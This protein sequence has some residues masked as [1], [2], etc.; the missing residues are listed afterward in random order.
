MRNWQ[1]YLLGL[2]ASLA[3]LLLVAFVILRSVTDD[4]QLKARVQAEIAQAT[5]AE[6]RLGQLHLS[7]SPLPQL[8]ASAVE[9]RNPEWQP[10]PPMKGQMREQM[11]QQ[12]SRQ[13]RMQVLVRAETMQA[14]IALMPL[15]S[16]RFELKDIALKGAQINLATDANGKH[17]WD[18]LYGHPASTQQG[19]GASFQKFKNT[20]LRALLIE[21]STVRVLDP[22]HGLRTWQIKAL[23]FSADQDLSDASLSADLIHQQHQLTIDGTI[24][25]L[26]RLGDEGASSKSAFKLKIGQARATVKGTL[27]LDRALTNFN[28]HV[29]IDAPSLKDPYAF[30]EIP[31]QST[32]ALK[33]AL[34]LV[35]DQQS[36]NVKDLQLQLG[37]MHAN[38]QGSITRNAAKPHFAL[39]LQAD[40]VDM[41]QTPLDLGR[42]PLPAKA[43][44]ELFY[45]HPLPWPML[46]K[47]QD[48]QGQLDLK[49]ASLRL[50]SGITVS[51]AGAHALF[52]DQSMKVST[53]NGKLLQGE[54]HGDA[55]FDGSKKAVQLNMHMQDV[56]LQ[57]WLK[58]GGKKL[59][60]DGGKMQIDA[61]L[62]TH[63]DS[64]KDLAAAING[65]IDI[66]IG[67]AV[68]QSQK[69]GNAEYWLT[70]LFS[71]KDESQVNMACA[72]AHLPFHAGVAQGE[73]IVGARS[74]DSQLLT[75][76][77]IDMR[78]QTLDLR[79]RVRA[80]SGVSLGLSTIAGDVKIVGKLSKPQL[81][82]DESGVFGAVAR[83]GAAIL[84]SGVSIIAT[85]IWDGANP[86]SDPCQ[87]VIKA[88]AAQDRKTSSGK[89]RT[90][91]DEAEADQ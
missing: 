61:H 46:A 18:V 82:L 73:A 56:L 12:I 23:A 15:L 81:D 72:A 21:D 57:E 27:P 41:V 45:D 77:E 55:L 32:A 6:L 22:G 65:P 51:D 71:A 10:G 84:T 78:K 24:D 79:G 4:A 40:K 39:T 52:D 75:G 29:D 66:R 50:R 31:H 28:L 26:S 19:T 30:L 70:G 7:F 62:D 86:A 88:N 25:D 74:D 64:M 37:E 34:Q 43:E 42:P 85:S 53:F 91:K 89:P 14:D 49:I 38:G 3:I 36:I 1:K 16:G 58:Q 90:T 48:T 17:N 83:V 80:R 9:L 47:L 2:A 60:V 76:G 69:A 13:P 5:G 35:A 68:I 59:K 44:G 63:G 8:Q 20:A 11:R 67:N 33:A 54:V 87:I